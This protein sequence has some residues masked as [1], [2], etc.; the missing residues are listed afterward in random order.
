MEGLFQM[1]NWKQMWPALRKYFT[2]SSMESY[3]VFRQDG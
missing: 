1:A 3:E 2:I